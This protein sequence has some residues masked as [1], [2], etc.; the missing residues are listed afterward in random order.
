MTPEAAARAL[1]DSRPPRAAVPEPDP[2]PPPSVAA[3][4]TALERGEPGP[5]DR[6]ALDAIVDRI[7]EIRE[8]EP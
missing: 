7:E 2:D 3:W 5:A 4:L 1:P 6:R 8:G